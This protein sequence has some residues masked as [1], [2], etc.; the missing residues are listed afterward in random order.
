M[1]V[2]AT[3]IAT[4][5]LDRY[6]LRQ[7]LDYFLLG[8]VIF[9]LI[10]FFSDTLFDFIQDV[11]KYGVPFPILLTIIGL[12]LPKSIAFVLPASC[13]LSVLL[14][15]S[16]MNNDF[17]LITMRM[18]GISLRRLAIPA[19]ILGLSASILSYLLH[20]YVVPYCNKQ[21]ELL[22]REVMQSGRLPFGRESFMYRTYDD[23][24][25]LLQLIYVGKY[26]GEKLGPSTIID[27][28]N[29]EAMQIVQAESG[30]WHPEKGWIFEN[31]NIY[32]PARDSNSSSA[33]HSDIFMVK[34]LLANKEHLRDIQIAAE[35]E[36]RG[37]NVES[38]QQ[39]FLKLL[40]SI[41]NREAQGKTVAGK[42]YLNLWEKITLPLT[43]LAIVLSAVGFAISP[44]RQ[45][46]QRGFAFALAILFCYYIA[47]HVAV[48]LGNTGIFTFGGLLDKGTS[49]M[50]AAWLP[51]LLIGAFGVL[52]L[53][54]K[55]KVL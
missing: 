8:V 7:A 5:L 30:R 24:H 14:V 4:T 54:R 45:G 50:I 20:D 42:S 1:Q 47:R 18:N 52:L 40:S 32:I 16:R 19:I 33:G 46:S 29:K 37:L 6:I 49:M 41:R 25:N 51:L 12:Q 31:A 13:F 38:D 43:C 15:Y 48:G 36:L 11:L 9:S 34:N 28:S 10:A 21:T 55:T 2:I 22:R 23:D 53:I 44:P 26:R 27:L 17:E 35:N 39:T 3:R